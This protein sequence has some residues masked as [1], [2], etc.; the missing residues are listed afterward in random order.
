[1]ILDL[2]VYICLHTCNHFYYYKT[3]KHLLSDLF[4]SVETY[5]CLL[6]HTSAPDS[7]EHTGTPSLFNSA[8]V[9]KKK[10]LPQ[11]KGSGIEAPLKGLAKR[12]GIVL[13]ALDTPKQLS[14]VACRPLPLP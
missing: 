3:S 8:E 6:P 7:F 12:V 9:G 4:I 11:A 13:V 5:L 14:E 1:M 2:F 10:K